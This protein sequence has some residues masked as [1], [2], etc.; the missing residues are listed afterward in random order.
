MAVKRCPA[1]ERTVSIVRAM[2]WKL[3]GANGTSMPAPASIMPLAT[4]KVS[5]WVCAITRS[6]LSGV[7][8]T[9]SQPMR[10]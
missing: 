4:K 3:G 7:C 2:A 9:T 8:S 5:A 1:S 10:S 6:W